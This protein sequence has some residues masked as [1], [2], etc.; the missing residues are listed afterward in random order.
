MEEPTRR[1][2]RV[3][4]MRS[5]CSLWTFSH[6]FKAPAIGELCDRGTHHDRMFVRFAAMRS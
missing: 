5:L 2:H 1:R 3:V 6:F 4:A